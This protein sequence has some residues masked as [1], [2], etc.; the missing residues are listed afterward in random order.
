MPTAEKVAIIDELAD[1]LKRSKGIYLADFSGLDVPKFTALRK[2]L[3]D[4]S[5]AFQVVKNRL[6]LLAMEKAGIDGI[7]DQF[8]G[9]T[10][11]VSTEEDAAL[12]AR[13]LAEFAKDS[14]GKP[15][16]KAGL[17]DGRVFDEAELEVLSKLP[18]RDVL[19]GQ[20][21]SALASPMSGLVFTLNGLLTKFVRTLHAVAEKKAEEEGAPVA[22]EA[23]APEA[24]S[25]EA[26]EG[27]SAEAPPAA[28]APTEEKDEAAPE[29]AQAA[30]E[31]DVAQ[32]G[33]PEA[34]PG[35]E[36]AAGSATPSENA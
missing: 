2:K 23:H 17:V 6:A 9:P 31:A 11:V 28:D 7:A 4:E 32:A 24:V 22:A 5:I 13:L 19:L 30:S 35:A 20:V 34:S 29:A 18:G 10:G 26:P 12:P 33:A 21:V 3:R 36:E 27:P 8:R 1:V 14:D 15:R 25:P 16:L